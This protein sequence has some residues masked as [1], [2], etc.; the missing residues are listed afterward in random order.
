MALKLNAL[1]LYTLYDGAKEMY[2]EPYTFVTDSAAVRQFRVGLEQQKIIHDFTLFK[3]GEFDLLSG[4]ISVFS[5]K[6][7]VSWNNWNN[8]EA[9]SAEMDPKELVKEM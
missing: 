5:D 4:K 6:K 2:S 8:L 3:I 9:K 7:V 1:G